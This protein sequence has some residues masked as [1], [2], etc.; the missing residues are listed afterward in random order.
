MK[1][2]LSIAQYIILS[3]FV[4]F[5]ILLSLSVQTPFAGRATSA[6]TVNI[7]PSPPANCS[8]SPHEGYNIVALPCL[9]GA[10]RVDNITNQTEVLA[11]YQYVPG[12]ADLW[13]VYNPN[14]PSYVVS[15]LQFMTRR[16]G[17]ITIMNASANKIIEGGQVDTSISVVSGW[18]LVGYPSNAT[19]GAGA[20]FSSISGQLTRA[21]T[22][23]KST[24]S[25]VHYPGD[26]L[27]HLIP[28]EGY[29]LNMSST[30]TWSVS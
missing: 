6:S 24:E 10:S 21:T 11:M 2:A 5:I 1:H 19:I 14:L 26:G 8:F 22:Y 25:F 18:N 27:I 4:L 20:G 12:D 3:C 29:W 23:N 7:I 9:I 30:T 13:R 15:D 28:G 17:Y 16:V